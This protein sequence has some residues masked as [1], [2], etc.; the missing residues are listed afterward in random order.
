MFIR[1]KTRNTGMTAIQIVENRRE[2]ERVKQ[3]VIRHV[4][5]AE[6]QRE[7]SELKRLAHSILLER[8]QRRETSLPLF[9]MEEVRKR[10]IIEECVEDTVRVKDLR[11][12]QRIT[13]GISDV[14]GSLYRDLQLDTV[15]AGTR[16]DAQ[17]NEILKSCVLGRLARPR[18]KRNTA[19]FLDEEYGVDIPL[20]KIYRMMDRFF[21]RIDEAKERIVR[22]TTALFQEKVDVLF[23]DVTTLYFESLD[24][25]ELR[26]FGF[27]KDC[28]FKEVQVVLALVTTRY[29]LPITYEVFPGDTFEGHTLQIA[30][31]KLKQRF[32]VENILIVADRAMFNWKNLDWMDGEKIRYI[33][34][35]KLRSLSKKMKERIL[36]SALYAPTE[37]ENELHWVQEFS[38]KDRRL[39]V[40][41]SSERAKRDAAQRTRLID[42]LF[43]KLK[44]G[45][46]GLQDLVTNKGTKKF[47]KIESATAVID[48]SKIDRDKEWDGLHGVISND[49]T[50]TVR[51]ILSRYRGLWQ[52]EAAFRVNKHDLRMRPIF[53]W[54]PKRIKAHIAICFLAY[55]IAKQATYRLG[56]IL[57]K[58]IS[59]AELRHQLLLVQSSILRDVS[60]QKRYLL[61]S[62]LSQKQKRIYSAF[63]LKR[64]ETPSVILE[65]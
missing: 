3:V 65:N 63:G 12:E 14:F 27:S 45:K 21:L 22:S 43:K 38:L 24:D 2:G 13:D 39:I 29:G 32:D 25:D 31:E 30:V 1:E 18:S 10:R 55:T 8:E 54:K 17:W 4:G 19:L 35:A 56:L 16:R 7:L 61:P 9:D 53:H 6:N 15:L 49:K 50:L 64:Q 47:L 5:Q 62:Q 33:V 36:H 58:P 48:E 59:F 52:I 60:T 28:K 26:D 46:I 11:E 57:K 41:Y 34:A 37:V 44:N 42:R 23:F 51:E 40:S 20:E